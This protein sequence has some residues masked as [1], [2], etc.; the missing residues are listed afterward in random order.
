MNI[1]P[2]ALSQL[3]G[4]T[5]NSSIDVARIV[6]FV[7]SLP[8]GSNVY[9]A[10][11]PFINSKA[12]APNPLPMSFV[13]IVLL[14]GDISFLVLSV[15]VMIQHFPKKRAEW[16]RTNSQG[17]FK[18]NRIFFDA[19]G[20]S[21]YA[22]FMI[23]EISCQ[24]YMDY[25]KAPLYGTTLIFMMKYPLMLFG[26][27][28]LMWGFITNVIRAIWDP[29][30][31]QKA[32]SSQ[33]TGP[34]WLSSVLNTI[35][36]LFALGSLVA[37]PLLAILPFLSH[38]QILNTLNLVNKR[39]LQAAGDINAVPYS[40][41]RLLVILT[42][43]DAI[44]ALINQYESAFRTTL[45]F[46]QTL[47]ASMTLMYAA[48]VYL[49]HREFRV[50]KSIHNS[51]SVEKHPGSHVK[52]NHQRELKNL[53]VET[54][55]GFVVLL[56]YIPM[57]YSA[58]TTE[59]G[60]ALTSKN[61]ITVVE[62]TMSMPTIIFGNI[63]MGYRVHSTRPSSRCAVHETPRISMGSISGF[64]M[65]N[66]PLSEDAQLGPFLSQPL[67]KIADHSLSW[68]ST[69]EDVFTEHSISQEV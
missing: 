62:L 8:P 34:K 12:C 14:L 17:V 47:D 57:F 37:L 31:R 48:F 40:L 9:A 61:L 32:Y 11:I 38:T 56:T 51:I 4:I 6:D 69:D 64:K 66:K 29:T 59:S 26:F 39:L 46:G 49:V 5:T 18:P 50:Y 36:I 33:V 52:L 28:C 15:L 25:Q 58:V 55:F 42:P 7:N 63:L 24:L 2:T 44:P 65:S 16:I 68:T 35:L 23:V 41:E 53:L 30:F 19:L 22:A 54:V 60:K 13:M 67:T 10:F 20:A 45:Y 3:N 21:V 27:W 1:E 43:M